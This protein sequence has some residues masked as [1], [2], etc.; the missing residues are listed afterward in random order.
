LS[1]S[2]NAESAQ[3]ELELGVGS[4]RKMALGVSL[5]VD[6]TQLVVGVGKQA[7]DELQQSG[8]VILDGDEDT[9]QTSF[10]ETA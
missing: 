7:R 5:H 9:T 1:S 2:E 8:E 4:L 3:T 10:D 6:D